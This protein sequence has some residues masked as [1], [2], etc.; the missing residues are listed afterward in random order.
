MNTS[1]ILERC[2]RRWKLDGRDYSLLQ[3][4]EMAETSTYEGVLDPTDPLFQEEG[5]ILASIDSYL[6]AKGW[7]LP[8][9]NADYARCILGAG[10]SE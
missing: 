10:K 7:P 3:L 8:A 4:E 9:N 1:T 2:R 5:D 6:F